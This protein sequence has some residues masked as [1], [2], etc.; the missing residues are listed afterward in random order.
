MIAAV[1]ELRSASCA[2]PPMAW[3]V[4]PSR[5]IVR[6]D[7]RQCYAPDVAYGVTPTTWGEGGYTAIAPALRARRTGD[8]RFCARVLAV[9]LG[10]ALTQ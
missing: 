3:P 10:A 6:P 7:A 4:N 8:A 9:A 1:D 2:V 5:P